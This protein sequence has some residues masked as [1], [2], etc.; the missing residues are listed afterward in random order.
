MYSIHCIQYDNIPTIVINNNTSILTIIYCTS[1]QLPYFHYFAINLVSAL[2]RKIINVWVLYLYFMCLIFS[3]SLL[4]QRTV[5]I[6]ILGNRKQLSIDI[7]DHCNG[8]GSLNFIIIFSVIVLCTIS[9]TFYFTEDADSNRPFLAF[10]TINRPQNILILFLDS[11]P[12]RLI[13]FI[14]EG[15][16]IIM[17]LI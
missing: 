17:I 4:L 9:L 6:L 2:N 7:T 8:L 14:I 10:V 12:K 1:V 11:I 15:I 16:K 5:S 3:I 13:Y